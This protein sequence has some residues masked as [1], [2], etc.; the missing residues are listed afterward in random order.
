MRTVVKPSPL[1]LWGFALTV[2]GGA[3]LAFGSISDWAAVSLGGSA[4]AAVPTKGIDLWQGKATLALG[5]LIL[6][7]VLG[8]RLVRPAWRGALAIAL[9]V[10]AVAALGLAIWCV[11]SLQSVVTD[12][13]IDALVDTV[14]ASFGISA[15][16][17]RQLVEGAMAGAGI[18]VQARTGLWLTLTGAI[19]ATA[20]GAVDLAWVRRKRALGDAID[21]DTRTAD[22]GEPGPSGDATDA[23]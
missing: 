13:G 20:G 6:V 7:G 10:L 5:A 11:T 15:Q 8:L 9:I 4:D 1:R 3:L 12:T 14:V 16:Q 22:A 18:E 17:A 21:V 2:L 23:S 19:V